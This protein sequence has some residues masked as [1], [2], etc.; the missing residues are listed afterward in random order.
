[1]LRLFK[2]SLGKEWA[3]LKRRIGAGDAD[4]L[5]MFLQRLRHPYPDKADFWFA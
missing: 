4:K 3:K 2:G 1:M 5:R